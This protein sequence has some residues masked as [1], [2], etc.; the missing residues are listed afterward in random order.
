MKSYL[1]VT[2][3]KKHELEKLK[4]RVARA[5]KLKARVNAIKPQVK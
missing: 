3:S 4:E 5:E 2:S 1:R